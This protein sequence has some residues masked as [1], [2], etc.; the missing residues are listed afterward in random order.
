MGSGSPWSF[1]RFKS[2]GVTYC[3]EPGQ[4]LRNEAAPTPDVLSSRPCKPFFEHRPQN[5]RRGQ[6]GSRLHSRAQPIL[7][8]RGLTST[9]PA[10][11]PGDSGARGFAQVPARLLTSL[12]ARY[13]PGPTMR[14]SMAG[15][16]RRRRRRPPQRGSPRAGGA[17]V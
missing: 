6:N 10:T 2:E 8:R 13:G 12:V 15:T 17:A 1:G 7:Q 4:C 14:C 11:R 5:G 3:R 16:E 9:R